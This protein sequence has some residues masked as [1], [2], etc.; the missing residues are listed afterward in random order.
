MRSLQKSVLE[1]IKS[2]LIEAATLP[3]HEKGKRTLCTFGRCRHNFR[4]QNLAM[5]YQNEPVGSQMSRRCN[6]F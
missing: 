2:V 6:W 3:R 5:M 1:T 4:N